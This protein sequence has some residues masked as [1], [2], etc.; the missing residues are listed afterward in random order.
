MQK[1][2]RYSFRSYVLRI[3]YNAPPNPSTSGLPTGQLHWT[4]RMSLPIAF[5]TSLPKLRSHSRT[6]SW[7]TSVR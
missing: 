3:S 1:N 6:G 5:E 4:V 7:P 2:T